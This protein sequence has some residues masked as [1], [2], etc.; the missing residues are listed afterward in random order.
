MWV[1]EELRKAAAGHL[2]KANAIFGIILLIGTYALNNNS[3]K[4]YTLFVKFYLVNQL[5]RLIIIQ[6]S[7]VIGNMKYRLSAL[8]DSQG[9]GVVGYA[10]F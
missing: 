7:Q 5:V 9:Q 4:I 1:V 3:P 6:C 8:K 10:S 2:K